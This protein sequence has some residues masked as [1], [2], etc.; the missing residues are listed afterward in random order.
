M[1]FVLLVLGL[2]GGG[3]ICLLVI[4]TTLGATSFRISQLQKKSLSL[5]T[6]EQNLRQQVA[7]EQAP[8]AIAER[9]YALGMR[10]QAGPA[11]LDLRTHRIYQLPWQSGVGVE[12]GA[13]PTATPTAAAASTAKPSTTKPGATASPAPSATPNPARSSP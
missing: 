7:A 1:P 2:L 8:G 3:L 5:S 4:N 12:L 11:I 13:P 6:Q 9:A 10:A